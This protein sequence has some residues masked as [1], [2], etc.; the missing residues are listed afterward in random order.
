M[1]PLIFEVHPLVILRENSAF[2]EVPLKYLVACFANPRETSGLHLT[3]N[4]WSFFLMS[5]VVI[6]IIHS[7]IAN[8]VTLQ[9]IRTAEDTDHSHCISVSRFPCLPNNLQ[10]PTYFL[11]S[12]KRRYKATL[13]VYTFY[14]FSEEWKFKTR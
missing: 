4:R 14:I 12:Q 11:T 5:L 3:E 2:F 6:I 10:Q 7:K 9:W 1:K 8:H 13:Y